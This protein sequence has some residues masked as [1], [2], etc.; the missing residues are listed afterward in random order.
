MYALVTVHDA[1]VLLI[2]QRLSARSSYSTMIRMR[3]GKLSAAEQMSDPICRS[4]SKPQP[5]GELPKTP[6]VHDFS[7][8]PPGL[9]NE[10]STYMPWP[11]PGRCALRENS[12]PP[13]IWLIPFVARIASDANEGRCPRLRAFKNFQIPRPG[14]GTSLEQD[15]GCPEE[16][17]AY[18]IFSAAEPIAGPLCRSKSKP[19]PR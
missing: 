13:S 4:N 1:L 17:R 16:V 14:W 5:R 18:G 19:Q 8:S 6:R 12:P 7:I 10:R 2:L 3:A 15:L 9:G 11:G